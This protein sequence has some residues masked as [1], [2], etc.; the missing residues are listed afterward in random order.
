MES[1][2]F[3]F[4]SPQQPSNDTMPTQFSNQFASLN[5][6]FQ[7]NHHFNLING[8][9]PSHSNQQFGSRFSYQDLLSS[10]NIPIEISQTYSAPNDPRNVVRDSQK[11][12]NSQCSVANKRSNWT[13]AE[14]VALTKAWLYVSVDSDI[15]NNQRSK[16]M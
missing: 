16:A 8:S 7:P 5:L 4:S 14:D 10:P 2:D 3:N 9:Y 12:N 6:P 15:G 13:K 11:S 1:E